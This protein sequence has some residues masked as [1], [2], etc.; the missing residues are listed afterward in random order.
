MNQSNSKV[1]GREIII[2]RLINAPRELIFDVWTTPEH[3]KHWYG[4]EGF[5][6]TT[7][8]MNLSPGGEWHFTMHGPDGRDYPNRIKFIEILRPEKL[9]YRHAGDDDTEPVDFHATITFE[10][11]NGA[12]MVTMR[13]TFASAEALQRVVETYGAVEGGKQTLSRLDSYLAAL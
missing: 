8:K 4:P 7:H 13:S 6:T 11:N 1:Q 9:V 12:T 10:D 2:T 5:I 3:V